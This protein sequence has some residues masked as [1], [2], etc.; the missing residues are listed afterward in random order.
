MQKRAKGGNVAPAD[1]A[2]RVEIT[3]KCALVAVPVPNA[4]AKPEPFK[5]DSIHKAIEGLGV[6]FKFNLR[7]LDGTSS[8]EKLE[9]ESLDDFEEATIVRK[10]V[11]LREL[12]RQMEFLHEF[13]NELRHN[14]VF[15]QE[16][17]EFLNSDQRG[18]FVQFLKGWAQQLKKPS[19]EFL[20]LLQS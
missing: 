9:I 20:K 10:S 7:H 18:Q 8:R 11:T 1:A 4:P 2:A 19:S 13:Q 3:E 14:P 6:S 17:K 5:A 12:K 15:R 16:L